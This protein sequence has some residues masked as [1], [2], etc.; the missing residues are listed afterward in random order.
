MLYASIHSLSPI[1]TQQQSSTNDYLASLLGASDVLCIFRVPIWQLEVR[2]GGPEGAL[3]LLRLLQLD[4]A[5]L[6]LQL[7]Q[8]ALKT[9][10]VAR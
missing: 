2:Y 8:L 7:E 6:P 3:G 4:E 10:L 1:Y 5:E 9:Q